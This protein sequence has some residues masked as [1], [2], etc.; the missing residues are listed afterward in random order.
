MSLTHHYW[1]GRTTP[2]EDK[3][4]LLLTMEGYKSDDIIVRESPEGQRYLMIGHWDFIESNNL[5]YVQQHCTIV[6]EEHAWEDA[7]CGW[8]FAYIIKERKDEN[9]KNDKL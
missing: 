9:K 5:N 1:V 2:T 7:D 4:K 3:I 8:Q 6:L